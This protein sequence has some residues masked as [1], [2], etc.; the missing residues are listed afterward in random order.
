MKMPRRFS[1]FTSG[2]LWRLALR[3][4]LRNRRR[5]IATGLGVTFGFAGMVLL[6]A[7]IFRTAKSLEV[8]S[9]YLNQRGHVAIRKAG[10]LD[11]FATKPKRYILGQNER[12]TIDSALAPFADK[13]EFS[14]D[15]LSGV[16]LLTDGAKSAPVI[17]TGI[18][19]E[20]YP[21]LNFHP[22]V[23]KWADD[24]VV[25]QPGSDLREMTREPSLISITSRVAE[26]LG[27][28][29][30]LSKI[31]SEK[32]DIQLI[33]KNFYHDLGA[34]DA[35]LG[36][37]HTTGIN[38]AEDTSMI[39]P[40]AL[41]QSVLATDGVEYVALFLHNSSDAKNLAR[42]LSSSL[43]PGFE[44][45][46]FKDEAWSPY[47]VGTMNFLYV[48][49]SFFVVLILGAVALT[50]VNTTTLNLLER[51]REI[52]TLRAIGFTPAHLR[53]MF[54][55]ESALLTTFSLITGLV[56]ATAIAFAVSQ[57]NIHY[58]PPG[59]QG[60]I[61]FFLELDPGV[62]LIMGAVA[63]VIT[64]GS[65]FVVVSRKGKESVIQL[66]SDSGA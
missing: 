4:L 27:R 41:L 21:R 44:V 16:G 45:L 66:L 65:T 52:G 37:Q 59:T 63:F 33:A 7:Y 13:I 50:I 57:M 55:R 9:A 3:S 10:S 47:Y 58:R 31:P 24:W 2:P 61:R 40:L 35:K 38:F 8:S 62:C 25:L 29:L 54:V 14:A 26:V 49:G 17:I 30:P 32:Q 18:D 6:G 36:A 56:I 19:P 28:P 64:V 11:K 12:L 1:L 15:F 48:M 23:K 39:A 43:G 53:A 5:T 20:I 51:S 60:A 22:E 42:S 34:V 46:T